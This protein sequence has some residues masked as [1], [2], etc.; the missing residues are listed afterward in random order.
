MADQKR[1]NGAVGFN[2]QVDFTD[3]TQIK[4]SGVAAHGPTGILYGRNETDK[5][6][7]YQQGTTQLYPLGTE[8]VYG[9]RHYR[10][11]KLAGSG[12]SQGKLLQQ[13]VSLDK[14]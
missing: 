4:I 10:Y 11:A 9:G 13:A 8:L 2:G 6:D 5:A 7:P 1:F 14:H 12:V 3:D